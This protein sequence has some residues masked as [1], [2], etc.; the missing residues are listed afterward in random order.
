MRINH[1]AMNKSTMAGERHG[2]YASNLLW[3]TPWGEE[4]IAEGR[5]TNHVEGQNCQ[6]CG[7]F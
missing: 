3:Q 5:S 2:E 4:N 1:L 6:H 7:E